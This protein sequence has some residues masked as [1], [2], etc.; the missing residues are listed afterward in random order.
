MTTG[1][2]GTGIIVNPKD[3]VMPVA[4]RHSPVGHLLERSSW[5][6]RASCPFAP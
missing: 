5:V 1:S 3:W 6:G 2:S 4:P